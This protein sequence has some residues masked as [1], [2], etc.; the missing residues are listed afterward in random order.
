MQTPDIEQLVDRIM[1]ALPQGFQEMKQEADQQLRA[2]LQ[3][4]LSQMDLVTR[5]EFDI[6]REVL[7]RTRSKLE[8]LEQQVAALEQALNNTEPTP[9]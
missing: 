6:Q 3:R 2:A 7:L 4:T 9:K 5:E 1:N 8:A